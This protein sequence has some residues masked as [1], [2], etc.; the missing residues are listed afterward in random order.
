MSNKFQLETLKIKH[1]LFL[2]L[3]GVLTVLCV[4]CQPDKTATTPSDL[5]KNRIDNYLKQSEA[6]GFSGAILVVKNDSII[7]NQGYG[8]ANKE[9]YIPNSPNTVYDICS[10]S[11]QFTGAAIMK[12]VQDNTL[13]LEDSISSF[14]D[15]LPKDKK[16]ITIHQLLTHSA[17]FGHGNTDD[18]DLTPMDV[19]FSDLF[20]SELLFTPGSD[21]SYS[22]SGYSILGRIIELVSG[23]DYETYLNEKLFQPSGMKHTG[24]LLPDWENSTVADEYLLNVSNEGSHI[25]QYKQDGAIARTVLANGGIHSTNNDMYK[26]YQSLQSNKILSQ[27]SFEILTKPH[28]AEYEDESSHYAYGWAIFT[29]ERGTKVITHNGFNG[30]SYN[31]FVWFPEE[32]ALI[33]LASN[34]YVRPIGRITL[35][36]ENIIFDST[37]VPN[38][39]LKYMVSELYKFTEAYQGSVND[40]EKQLKLTYEEV[41]DSPRHL[42]RLGGVYYRKGMME[43]AIGIYK[44]NIQLFPDDGNSWDSLGD[45]YFKA[46]EKANAINAFTRAL[47]LKPE[48]DDCFWCDNSQEKL[49]ILKHN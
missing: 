45:T 12:L 8:F 13:K 36:I 3:A 46:D 40:L 2:I 39:L 29:S 34:A 16:D 33:L 43:K 18:F 47:E 44:L 24:Y 9:K 42:N 23:Q 10:V 41:I 14:F 19:Y 15:N 27:E 25:A 28:V 7:L 49:E 37:Y 5:L 31:E 17:G 1:H 35:E 48:N 38:E 21:Y 30:V 26:W 11:K 4:A 20:E 22:N 32:D 6:N